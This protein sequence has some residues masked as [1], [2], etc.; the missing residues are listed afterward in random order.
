[1][2]SLRGYGLCEHHH[3]S[4][5]DRARISIILE[6]FVNLQIT[7][8]EGESKSKTFINP[9]KSNSTGRN[10]YEVTR[11]PHWVE[12]HRGPVRHSQ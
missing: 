11:K 8:G 7:L 10:Y 4:T 12:G 6:S 2:C 5:I 9:L 3:F 1:M